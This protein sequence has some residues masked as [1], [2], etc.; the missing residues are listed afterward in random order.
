[1]YVDRNAQINCL[2]PY[3]EISIASYC[4]YNTTNYSFFIM[5]L[6]LKFCISAAQQFCQFFSGKPAD[7]SQLSIR[8][9]I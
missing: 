2:L 5:L 1:M 3:G 6:Q 7:F 9:G 8:P 4:F